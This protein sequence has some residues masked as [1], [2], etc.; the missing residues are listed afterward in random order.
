MHKIDFCEGDMQLVGVVTKNV[1]EN[2]LNHRM[3]YIMV[4]LD[5]C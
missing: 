4:S 3:K 5:N 2:N 1:G